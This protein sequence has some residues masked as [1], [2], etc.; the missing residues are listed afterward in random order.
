MVR[1]SLAPLVKL[2][3][4]PPPLGAESCLPHLFQL[5]L[6]EQLRPTVGQQNI[7]RRVL[8]DSV[9]LLY[10]TDRPFANGHFTT[11]HEVSLID[12]LAVVDKTIDEV[13]RG[14]R[15]GAGGAEEE[16][17]MLRRPVRKLLADDHRMFREGLAGM[18][19]SSYAEQV[20]VVGKT[21]IGEDAIALAQKERPDVV[22]MQVDEDLEKAKDNLMQMREGS[23]SPPTVII[24]TMFEN[25]RILR[26]VMKLGSNAFVHK[27]ASVEELLSALRTT[28]GDPMGE[29]VVMMMPQEVLK[30]S[31]DG[32]AGGVLTKKELEV[33]VLAARGLTNRQ[34]ADS[35][36]L[37]EA[38]VKRH[39]ANIYPKMGV[40]TRGE[41]M[42]RALENEWL[43][44][45][46]ITADAEYNG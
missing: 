30:E 45:H 39:L 3:E 22:I 9:A 21:R 38:T 4:D 19:A 28:V 20:E 25:P 35:L 32:S 5:V 29:N 41:A 8:R 40:H 18:L 36:N 12:L 11:I 10:S 13:T 24:L 16:Q 1:S 46:E 6:P 15:S 26:E 2:P 17:G 14:E 33:L 44:I 27:S 23:S 7:E 31:E 37:A 43:T 34:I 42:C